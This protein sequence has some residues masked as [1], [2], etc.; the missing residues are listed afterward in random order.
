MSENDSSP[1]TLPEKI[2]RYYSRNGITDLLKESVPFLTRQIVDRQKVTADEIIRQTNTHQFWEESKE[3]SFSI[4]E[5]NNQRLR[6][7]FKPYPKKFNPRPGTVYEIEDCDLIGPHAIGLYEGK[8]LISE[9]SGFRIGNMFVGSRGE[10]IIHNTKSRFKIGPSKS[11]ESVFPLISPDPSYYHWMMEYLPKLRLLELYQKE[12]GKEPTLL[13]E[14]NP[15]DFV[16][17][18]LKA[19]GY[20]STQYTEW[21][22]QETRVEKLIVTTHRPH[23][24]NYETPELS[25]YNPSIR[26]FSW[27]RDRMRSNIPDSGTNSD[28]PEKVYISRQE[29]SRERKVVNQNQLKGI[30]EKYGFETYKL[31]T[32]PFKEQL[33]TFYKA[34]VIMGPHGAGLL[35]MIFADDP[36]VIELFPES[37]IKPHFHFLADMFDFDYTSMITK[38]EENNLIIDPDELDELLSDISDKK[39]QPAV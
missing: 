21:D 27:L 30:L 32:L 6:S 4:S 5:S 10:I 3:S 38:S 19:A 8:N 13:I 15:R 18:T 1:P 7:E 14:S 22:Q 12:T 23:I 17:D 16:C 35:N 34:D 24:F 9:T 33:E 36:T 25:N 39:S 2:Y 31:E 29:A 11:K 20:D 26:D 28:T 37:V